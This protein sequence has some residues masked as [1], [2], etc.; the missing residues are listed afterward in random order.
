MKTCE[1]CGCG[2]DDLNDAMQFDHPVRVDEN[3]TVHDRLDGVYAPEL[4]MATTSDGQILAQHEADYADQARRQGW[5]L[6]TGWT[7]QD[8][9]HGV[10]MHPSEFVGGRLERHIRETPG[11]Y[12]VVEVRTD[13]DDEQP[14]GW[15]V[16][17]RPPM[18]ID[19]DMGSNMWG[20]LGNDVRDRLQAVAD[21]PDEATWDDAHSIIL[22]DDTGQPPV[23]LWQAVCALDRSYTA[24]GPTSRW[25]KDDSNLGGHSV[26]V[27]G[28][29]KIPPADLIRQAI[30]YATR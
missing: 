18:S 2:Q 22:R 15:A 16:A 28:W 5:E 23:T 12:V 25:V 11:T 20:K 10:V 13:D 3:G 9:Y 6:L 21:H 4:L 19:L 27:S 14:T 17:Y 24:I 29:K 30:N 1:S 8:R 26:P 7:G